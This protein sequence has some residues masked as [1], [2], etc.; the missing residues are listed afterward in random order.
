VTTRTTW[1]GQSSTHCVQGTLVYA[2]TACTVT[3]RK[4]EI[5]AVYTCSSARDLD[6]YEALQIF[7]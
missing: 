1:P 5:M 4:A 3:V 7:A 2:S 6:G